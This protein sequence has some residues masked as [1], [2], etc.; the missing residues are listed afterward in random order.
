MDTP[1]RQLLD[2]DPPPIRRRSA[3]S[4]S[5]IAAAAV[6]G[7]L[8][9]IVVMNID[10]EADSD[11]NDDAVIEL[12]TPA[13]LTDDERQGVDPEAGVAMQPRLERGGWV[14]FTDRETGRL[15]QQYRCDRLDPNPEGMPQGWLRMEQPRMEIYLKNNRVVTLAGESAVAYAP[16][17]AIEMG[18][19][20]GNVVL[21]LYETEANRDVD[22]ARDQPALTV[23]T[24]EASFESFLGEI[25]CDDW[26]RIETPRL[27]IP[28]NTLSLL[29]DDQNDTIQLR[30]E[31]YEY[32]RLFTPAEPSPSRTAMHGRGATLASHSRQTAPPESSR[33]NAAS[34]VQDRPA[35]A[36]AEKTQFYLLTLR[37][38]IRID[39]DSRSQRRQ[40]R[41]E[42]LELV[43][44]MESEGLDSAVAQTRPMIEFWDT[45]PGASM[46]AATPIGSWTN[47]LAATAIGIA[48]PDEASIDSLL[49]PDITLIRGDGP[50]TV[51]P[52]D[53]PARRPPTASDAILEL[54]GAP[55][56]LCD[57]AGESQA[58]GERVR[59][60]SADDRIEL[61]GSEAHPLHIDAPEVL[62]SGDRFWVN[63]RESRA[64]FDGA[65]WLVS[66]ARARTDDFALACAGTGAE[67]PPRSASDGSPQLEITWD[68]GMNLEF[69]EDAGD[70]RKSRIRTTR[71]TG[72][73]R[74]RSEEFTLDA[75]E[76]RV[77]FPASSDTRD[78]IESIHASG[79]VRV[80]GVEQ[81]GSILCDDLDLDLV[82]SSTGRTIPKLMLATGDV[83][84]IDEDQIIWAD[85]LRVRFIEPT[86][87][88]PSDQPKVDED[89]LVSRDV[90]VEELFAEHDVQ[91]LLANGTR[92]FADRLVGD[93]VR[94]AVVLT[95]DDVI[96]VNEGMILDQGTRLELDRTTG[97]A[98]GPGRL[99]I[100]EQPLIVPKR[101]RVQRP[102]LEETQNPLQV[103]ATWRE[104]MHFDN[105]F[106]DGAGSV[107][108]RGNVDVL[109]H[110]S[111][112]ERT[113]MVGDA[114]TL[115][116]RHA[117]ETSEAVESEPSSP[118]N[119]PHGRRELSKLIARGNAKIESHEWRSP[120]HAEESRI[121]YVAG[122]LVEFDN[123]S[124][125]ALAVGDVELLLH[126]PWPEENASGD[127]ATPFGAKGST[128]L[129]CS[130]QAR[131]TPRLDNVFDLLA[132]GDVELRHRDLQDVSSWLT[133]A[134]LEAT[135][136]RSEDTS[137]N[138]LDHSSTRLD[139]G[140]SGTLERVHA[141]GGAI[142][143][144]DQRDIQCD[145]FDYD[146]PS[147]I[148]R[149]SAENGRNV[150][151]QTRG[152]AGVTRARQIVW[153]LDRDV[154]RITQPAGSG[155]P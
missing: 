68:S 89:R 123:R 27:R 24:D 54:T 10:P 85:V 118:L 78:Q 117:D 105:T 8:L 45:D 131:L 129:R 14:Q 30:I 151:I 143:R 21:N 125:A 67:I 11:D 141:T 46:T 137:N 106:N 128:M 145:S 139:L 59:Y 115:E 56:A 108:F 73:V 61:L 33:S 49:G 80:L 88:P 76:V 2:D 5:L 60:N 43:F 75:H 77:T 44:S 63:N 51:V 134:E 66:G 93:G 53:D 154:I 87:A 74:V 126:D 91:V 52:L 62:A 64:G 6:F 15:A 107:D 26:V 34:P 114:L 130:K 32:I 153:H 38:R 9:I 99:R 102:S 20:S 103:V 47:A 17:R 104:A 16:H 37:D 65:G 94:E 13:P 110:P 71:F 69:A 133:C 95:G 96:I 28:G 86:T 155:A 57:L 147:A 140:G 101:S 127:G 50:L 150:I 55:V 136:V 142:V 4:I 120:D 148:A 82:Q 19:V 124:G 31:R 39:Q 40:A 97:S 132:S 90:L 25:R 84:A 146:V 83:Q 58:F 22:P 48:P 29:V 36:A 113:T 18:T 122:R 119:V 121:F 138:A 72:N 81:A 135:V 79:D 42:R 116:F 149:L 70:E 7:A 23:T 12:V 98:P 111:P 92:A 1:R 35:A 41:G 112:L 100:F 109:S 144:T 3:R 152:S